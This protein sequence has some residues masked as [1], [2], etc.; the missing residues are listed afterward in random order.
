ML[1]VFEEGLD[2]IEGAF[3]QGAIGAVG[4][5]GSTKP[6]ARLILQGTMQT[7]ARNWI[8]EHDWRGYVGKAFTLEVSSTVVCSQRNAL[9]DWRLQSKNGPAR[10]TP[11]GT[12]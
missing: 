6:N 2:P 5:V 7:V 12:R 11:R 8:Q 3:L 4:A 1:R 9:F 10:T